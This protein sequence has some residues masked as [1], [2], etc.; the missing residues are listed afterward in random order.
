M[1]N[2]TVTICVFLDPDVT[3]RLILGT[4]ALA[5]LPFQLYNEFTRKPLLPKQVI[6]RPLPT[7]K[8]AKTPEVTLSVSASNETDSV[9]NNQGTNLTPA[10]STNNTVTPE[11]QSTSQHCKM[12][13]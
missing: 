13:W 11:V 7:N 6:F 5:V 1:N 10:I 12:I 8:I 3:D 2:Y 4:P 9:A